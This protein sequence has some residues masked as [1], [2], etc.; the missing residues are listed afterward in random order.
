MTGV[1]VLLALVALSCGIAS[2]ALS[3]TERDPRPCTSAASSQV[4]G[5]KAHT[6]WYPKGCKHG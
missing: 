3:L 5:E 4:Q 1:V 6:V 2:L